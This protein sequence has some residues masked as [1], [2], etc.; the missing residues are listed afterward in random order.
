MEKSPTDPLPVVLSPN[1]L[2]FD[3]RYDKCHMEENCGVY[4]FLSLFIREVRF[5]SGT[6]PFTHH[7]FHKAFVLRGDALNRARNPNFRERRT[8]VNVDSSRRGSLEPV[9]NLTMERDSHSQKDHRVFPRPHAR[10]Y[11]RTQLKSSCMTVNLS[12]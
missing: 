4:S 2:M 11:R 3:E 9:S 5:V 12:D 10:R 7:S 6:T 1:R 8:E